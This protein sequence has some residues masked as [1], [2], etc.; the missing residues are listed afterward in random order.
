MSHE[1]GDD[2]LKSNLKFFPVEFLIGT[3]AL[4][5]G[6]AALFANPPGDYGQ[7]RLVLTLLV[8]M[9]VW[10]MLT[11]WRQRYGEGAYAERFEKIRFRPWNIVFAVIAA[12]AYF[13]VYGFI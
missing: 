8:L 13:I 5:A 7:W 2:K 4:I 12:I 1:F 10:V 11:S 3:A 9:S 6:I